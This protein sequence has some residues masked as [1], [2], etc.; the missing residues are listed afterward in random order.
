MCDSQ[1]C[2]GLRQLRRVLVSR[3]TAHLTEL[4]S[5]LFILAVTGAS[6]VCMGI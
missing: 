1:T 3:I 5:R 6:V 2:R 4:R